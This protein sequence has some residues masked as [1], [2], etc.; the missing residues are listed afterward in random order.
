MEGNGGYPQSA[1]GRAAQIRPPNRFESAHRQDDFEQLEPDDELVADRRAIPT[2][3]LPDDSK[4]IIRENDS[5]DVG[6]R[7]SINPYR[8]CE[9]GCVY[10][11]AR[12]GHETL[13]MDA[14]LDFETKIL[15][16]HDAARLLR[17]E[18]ARPAWDGEFIAI[19]GVTDCYQPI[20]RKLRLTRSCLEVLLEARQPVG[21]ITKNV[22]MLRDL[23]LLA[24]MAELR[25]VHVNLSVTTLDGELARTMEPRTAT[26]A[27]KLRAIAEL[28]A[29]GVPTRVMVA[30]IVP[31]LTDEHVPAVLEAAAAAGAKAAGFVLLRLPFAV[32]PIF[33]DWLARNFP[34]KKDR[35]E[36]LI[37]ST[38]GGRMS[39]PRWG[40]R[41][42]GE[43]PYAEQIARTFKVFAKKYGLDGPLPPLDSSQF[44]RPIDANGQKSL[45]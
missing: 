4:T 18:L 7:F 28:T 6:F 22:L 20:E 34:L 30:P 25:L 13:G 35:V 40:S 32:L 3:F 38:R 11:Y 16:K 5:P 33:Q 24:P 21:I 14:G 31:G 23:D 17:R 10:C 15:V 43:G 26:P 2:Q 8:G 27:A 12:P 44:R 42:R 9:H 19:S 1:T 45:F 41:M 36:A 37:R 39:D 29:A